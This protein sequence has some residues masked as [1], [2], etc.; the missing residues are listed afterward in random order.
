MRWQ[1]VATNFHLQVRKLVSSWGEGGVKN[2]VIHLPFKCAFP[3]TSPTLF[4]IVFIPY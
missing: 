1:V 2:N 4:E 3:Y